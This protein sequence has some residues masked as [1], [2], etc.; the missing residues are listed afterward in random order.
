MSLKARQKAQ[1]KTTND[2]ETAGMFGRATWATP[3][4]T[5]VHG[6]VDGEQVRIAVLG[7]QPGS[8]PVYLCIDA[9]GN[10]AIV[11]LTDVTI[12]DGAYL[13]LRLKKTTR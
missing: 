1:Q 11:P 2:T 8:S 4:L 7:D 5:P 9:D 10:S 3:F 12:T 13:P 6:E